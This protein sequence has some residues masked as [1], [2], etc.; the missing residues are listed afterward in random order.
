MRESRKRS[1]RCLCGVAGVW[2]VLLASPRVS[3]AAGG[4]SIEG[5]VTILDREGTLKRHHEGVVVFVDEVERP[6]S[7][8]TPTAHAVVRQQH[9]RFDPEVL[10]I[11][12]GT[13]VDFPNDDTIYHNV[14][15][16][17]KAKPFDLGI[18]EQGGSRSVTFDQ[19]G[20][21]K[22]Y[23]NIH[24][25]MAAYIL[26]LPNAYFAMTD[27]HGRFVI[28]DAPLGTATVRAWY[29]RSREQPERKVVVTARGIQNLDFS[30]V[31]SLRLEIR[32]ETISL[33]HKNKWGQDY[34]AKY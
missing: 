2:L 14:F 23:C 16:L 19:P 24:S 30:V 25:Q 5:A 18:Y 34:P 20:L 32:E 21:V 15:S 8:S 1:V 9:K 33:E 31:E 11:V 10:P 29:P 13:T 17:S 7:V 4:P 26:V 28:A 6:R 3:G 12:V 27:P 22:L